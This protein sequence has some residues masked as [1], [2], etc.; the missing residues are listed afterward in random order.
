MEKKDDKKVDITKYPEGPQ[1]VIRYMDYM[2]ED[3][4]ARMSLL[5]QY[6]LTAIR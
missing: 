2:P 3:D 4:N 1:A 6:V 5:M